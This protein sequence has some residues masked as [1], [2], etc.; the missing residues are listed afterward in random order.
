MSLWDEKLT[1]NEIDGALIRDL[2][3]LSSKT[4]KGRREKGKRLKDGIVNVGTLPFLK[5]PPPDAITKE[6]I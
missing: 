5:K 4:T 1:Q 3:D 6:M 2:S